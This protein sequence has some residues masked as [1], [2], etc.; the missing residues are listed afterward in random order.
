MKTKTNEQFCEAFLKAFPSTPE[1]G[2]WMKVI[3][4]QPTTGEGANI[5]GLPIVDYYDGREP[6]YLFSVLTV[7]CKWAEKHGW[8][9]ELHDAGTVK[10]YPN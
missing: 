3:D 7:V 4:G 6:L 8:R 9:A 5:D 1:N 10:F 2:I